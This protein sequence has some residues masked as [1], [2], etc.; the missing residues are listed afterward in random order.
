VASSRRSRGGEAE[1]GQFDGVGCGVV[2]VRP[3]YSSLAVIS[4]SDHRGILV[5]C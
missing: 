5:F 2:E 4:F 1:D 3:K